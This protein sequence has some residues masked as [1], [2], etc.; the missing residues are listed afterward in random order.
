MAKIM[1]SA[2]IKELSEAVLG[3]LQRLGY[4]TQTM[5]TYRTLYNKLLRF[6]EKNQIQEFSLEICE[7]WLKESLGIDPALVV[8]RKENPYKREFYLPIRVCQC[9]TEWQLH[10]CIALKKQGK[11]AAR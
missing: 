8:T 11:L 1:E 9:L 10:G 3:E 6:A 4:A 5:G 7:R 2:T